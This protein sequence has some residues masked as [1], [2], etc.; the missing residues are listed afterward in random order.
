MQGLK[1]SL[2]NHNM[3]NCLPCKKINKM[4]VSL[5]SSYWF[6]VLYGTKLTS[7]SY[8][9]MKIRAMLLAFLQKIIK[10]W[11]SLFFNWTSFSLQTGPLLKTLEN[12]WC[13]SCSWKGMLWISYCKG[14]QGSGY[15]DLFSAL[16]SFLF[17]PLS[18]LFT[19]SDLWELRTFCR[20]HTKKRKA[21]T[22]QH[23]NGK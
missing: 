1:M 6:L 16:W 4:N 5:L 10:T 11:L 15:P 19:F 20:A 18:K 9:G 22:V 17:V 23:A 21:D 14:V 12:V 2:F 13:W 3:T 7:F 8:T